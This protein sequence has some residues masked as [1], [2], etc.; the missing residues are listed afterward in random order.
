MAGLLSWLVVVAIRSMAV[1]ARGGARGAG[2]RLRRGRAARGPQLGSGISTRKRPG[3]GAAR[4]GW[5]LG[6]C[7]GTGQR[8]P[9]AAHANARAAAPRAHALPRSGV[10]Q[11]IGWIGA[12]AGAAFL[13][14]CGAAVGMAAAHG[15]RAPPRPYAPQGPP[16]VQWLGALN[17]VG[18]LMFQ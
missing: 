2:R 5:R 10:P 1:G 16:A 4:C 11:H 18:I 14:Y 6:G 7:L 3:R 12:A 17:G 8:P 13:A 9:P 15:A